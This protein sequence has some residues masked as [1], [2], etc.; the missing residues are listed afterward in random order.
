MLVLLHAAERLVRHGG[1]WED[2]RPDG[3][4]GHGKRGHGKQDEPNAL[5]LG[6]RN[7]CL[8][9]LK[10]FQAHGQLPTSTVI[11]RLGTPLKKDVRLEST[12]HMSKTQAKCL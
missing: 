4:P 10:G 3:Q 1:A 9:V 5:A 8:G 6:R 12:F 2:K 7:G 11:Q